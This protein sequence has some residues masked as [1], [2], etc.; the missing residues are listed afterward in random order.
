M[1]LKPPVALPALPPDGGGPA[2]VVEGLAKENAPLGLLGAGV[3]E[4]TLPNNPLPPVLLIPP[5]R[6]VD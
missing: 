2:G 4:A 6:L 5:K 3:D 1:K